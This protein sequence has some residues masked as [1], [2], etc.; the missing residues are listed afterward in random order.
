MLLALF[1]LVPVFLVPPLK[2]VHYA[3]WVSG[4]TVGWV[5]LWQQQRQCQLLAS[6]TTA[7]QHRG[8]IVGALHGLACR[9]TLAPLALA[10]WGLV[11]TPCVGIALLACLGLYMGVIFGCGL[12]FTLASRRWSHWLFG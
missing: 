5:M 1:G 8:P 7:Q 4:L 6:A 3:A 2:A 9:L 12:S 10:S 11:S